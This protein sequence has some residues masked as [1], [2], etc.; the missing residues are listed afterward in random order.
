[1]PATA[2]EML[3]RRWNT[4]WPA[5]EGAR[6]GEIAR[7]LKMSESAVKVSAHRMRR[8]YR[9][10]LRQEIAQTVADSGMIEDEIRELLASL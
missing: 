8:R 9:E 7:K 2:G 5:G 1:M 3:L 10:L 4:C 6:Y